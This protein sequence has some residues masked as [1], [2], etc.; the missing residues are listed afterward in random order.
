MLLEKI[1]NIEDLIK[2]VLAIHKSLPQWIPL[3]AKYAEECG[4]KTIDGLRTHCKNNIHP[5]QFQ[6]FGNKWY[7]HVSVLHHVKRV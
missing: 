7:I 2:E 5:D 1:E 3:S 4:Y 6:K